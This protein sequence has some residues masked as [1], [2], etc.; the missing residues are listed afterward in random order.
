VNAI[1]EASAGK[2]GVS[3][4]L[5]TAAGF[6]AGRNTVEGRWWSR[7]STLLSSA[8]NKEIVEETQETIANG[9]KVKCIALKSPREE[10]NW[11]IPLVSS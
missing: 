11:G 2:C 6:F 5:S 4:Q 10:W 8:T 3:V 9:I 7:F 1:L